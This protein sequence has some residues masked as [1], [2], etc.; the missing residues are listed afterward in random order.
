MC[1]VYV[2]HLIDGDVTLG[3]TTSVQK[4]RFLQ[5]IQDRLYHRI[6]PFDGPTRLMD[7]VCSD[8]ENQ[9]PMDA[10]AD[11]RADSPHVLIWKNIRRVFECEQMGI[12]LEK[13]TD[14][15]DE[16]TAH[17]KKDTLLTSLLIEKGMT[18][19]YTTILMVAFEND[20]P[21]DYLE[22]RTLSLYDITYKLGTLTQYIDDLN[23]FHKDYETVSMTL[24]VH[25]YNRDGSLDRYIDE[26]N[27]YMGY[28]SETLCDVPMLSWM[29]Y[30]CEFAIVY[31]CIK[32][33]TYISSEMR[34]KLARHM[35]RLHIKEGPILSM[36]Q[37]KNSEG[38]AYL[39]K[40]FIE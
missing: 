29:L 33:T 2:D 27:A 37:R 13:S 16:S 21:M 23:D 38:L 25:R 4:K 24:A 1:Y 22:S 19:I 12:R 20:L 32:H 8:M 6:E 39:T 10:I 7:R 9:V 40:L 15:S 3:Y 26:V 28:V 35:D 34:T 30:V 5:Y 36:R 18:T 11:T 17:D 14:Q 31:G